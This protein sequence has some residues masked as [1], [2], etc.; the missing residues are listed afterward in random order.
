MIQRLQT[1]FLIL[2]G[3][4]NFFIFFT[5]IYSRAQQDP[6]AWIGILFSVLLT[7]AML[8]S[9]YAIFLYKD[10]IKQLKWVGYGLYFQVAALAAGA[11]ILFTL[12][13][14]GR[15]LMQEALSVLLL[16]IAL[17]ALLLAR[18]YIRKDQELVESMDRIR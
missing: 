2:A 8:L 15:F 1:V 11:G 6:A 10:R 17:V 9:I 14:F 13:G 7:G 4:I 3:L 12:G 5:P 18:R 16:L